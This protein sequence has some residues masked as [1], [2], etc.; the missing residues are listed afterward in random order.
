STT[1]SH[2]PVEIRQQI[3]VTDGL[4]RISVGLEDADDIIAD[5]VQALQSHT[6]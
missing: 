5:L 1:H 4:V 2:V 3:G 6:S